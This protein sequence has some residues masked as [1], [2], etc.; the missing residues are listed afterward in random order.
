MS[1]STALLTDHYELT[2]IQAALADG[3]AHRR[4]VFEAFARQLP[5]GRRYGV[6][7]GIQR[8]AG[9]VQEFRF[10]EAQLGFL[11]DSGVISPATA[12]W[13]ANYRF[14]GDIDCYSE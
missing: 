6:V 14:T 8:L 13:L 1:G 3:T 12:R 9:A 2:M 11:R 5:P 4:C 7:A 10:D